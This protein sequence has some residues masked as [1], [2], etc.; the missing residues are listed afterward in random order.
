MAQKEK[1]TDDKLTEA[2][3]RYSE[4]FSGKIKVTELAKW[5]SD[6]IPGLDGVQAH[7]FRGKRKIVNKRTGKTEI[8]VLEAFERIQTIN[9]MRT[10][11]AAVRSNALFRASVPDVFLGL[12]RPE[13]RRQ[14]LEMRGQYEKLAGENRSLSR[15]NNVLEAENKELK[16]NIEDLQEKFAQIRERQ[17]LID[18][19]LSLMVDVIDKEKKKEILSSMGVMDGGF[20]LGT[21]MESLHQDINSVFSIA[22]T[23]KPFKGNPV[24]VD[25]LEPE[26]D[27]TDQQEMVNNILGGLDI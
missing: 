25:G 23:I 15:H 20:D 21:Y 6:N 13:Q 9:K 7:N 4:T 22:Q 26:T 24:T 8:L 10:G 16:K 18:R 1:Y 12:P 17:D 14:I 2:V 5:A 3:V 11:E 19:K 27:N